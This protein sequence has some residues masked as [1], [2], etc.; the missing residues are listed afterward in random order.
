MLIPTG[1]A[2]ADTPSR[3]I[4]SNNITVAQSG[5]TE[6]L[7]LISRMVIVPDGAC[8]GVSTSPTDADPML[9]SV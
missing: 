2:N 6:A 7:S 9:I 8:G 4:E 3:V 1:Q 5:V